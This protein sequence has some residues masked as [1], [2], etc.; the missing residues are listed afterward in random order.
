MCRLGDDRQ[1]T[2]DA[3]AQKHLCGRPADAPRDLT[4]LLAGDVRL[5][6]QVGG[7]LVPAEMGRPSAMTA[8][9]IRLAGDLLTRPDNTVSSIARLLGVSRATLYKY[10]PPSSLPGS[11]QLRACQGPAVPPGRRRAAGPGPQR[12]ATSPGRRTPAAPPGP[13]RYRPGFRRRPRPAGRG[14]R[15]SRPPRRGPS[16]SAAATVPGGQ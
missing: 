8:E 10:V 3:P 16:G 2:L 5:R 14:I 9:Q 6:V 11:R 12:T 7:W 4:D 13:G 1:L 15:R